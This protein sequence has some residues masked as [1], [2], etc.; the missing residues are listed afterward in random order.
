MH[1]AQTTTGK[2]APHEQ[3][4]REANEIYDDCFTHPAIAVLR[5]FNR[6]FSSRS[7]IRPELL[8]FLASMAAYVGLD[9]RKDINW[10]NYSADESMELLAIAKTG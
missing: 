4:F 8:L 7:L 9:P 2:D 6:H 1:T 3:L 10:V 5:L